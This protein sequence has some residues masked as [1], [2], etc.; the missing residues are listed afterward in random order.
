MISKAECQKYQDN[1]GDEMSKEESMQIKYQLQ[2]GI[3]P[4]LIQPH[5][6][7]SPVFIDPAFPF[8][9]TILQSFCCAAVNADSLM[10]LVGSKG[11]LVAFQGSHAFQQGSAAHAATERSQR[12]L[13]GCPHDYLDRP[14]LASRPPKPPHA[15]PC[16][17]SL[18]RHGRPHPELLTCNVIRR[19]PLA[20]RSP[21]I[22]SRIGVRT[23]PHRA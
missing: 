14:V 2:A 7:C 1:L 10:Q 23:A 9:S 8:D 20:E 19:P 17:S 18:R 21:E 22:S 4:V 3:K 6:P 16:H 13:A 11:G 15:F 12:A 5:S